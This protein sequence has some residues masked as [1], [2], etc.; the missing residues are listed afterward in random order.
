MKNSPESPQTLESQFET[1]ADLIITGAIEPLKE[2]LNTHPELV[3]TRSTREHRS[4]LLHYTAANGVEDVRQETPPNI[5]AIANLL[6]DAGAEVDAESE[7]YGG[8][9]TTLGLAATSI[10]PQKAGVQLDLL[11]TLLD[12][13]ASLQKNS[14]GNAHSIVLGCLANGQ[15]EAASFLA[16]KGAPLDVVS[17]AGLNRLDDLQRL[18]QSATPSDLEQAL[19][20]AEGYGALDTAR[21][22]RDLH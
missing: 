11:Q 9:C 1:A 3:H 5:V 12:R 15:P 20:Y 19:R 16:D 7:A 6:L 4:T 2:L 18:A 17:A 14:A 10:H 8:G 22:L 13:G 21:Y